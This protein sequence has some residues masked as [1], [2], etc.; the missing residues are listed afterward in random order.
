MKLQGNTP[1]IWVDDWPLKY[2]F[3]RNYM[4]D[5]EAE[6]YDQKMEVLWLLVKK[7]LIAK[8]AMKEGI[9]VPEETVVQELNELKESE[10]VQ[11]V[12]EKQELQVEDIKFFLTVD[13]LYHLF[14][15]NIKKLVQEDLKKNPETVREIYEK[16]KDLVMKNVYHL[17]EI[18]ITDKPSL[19]TEKIY[20]LAELKELGASLNHLG[21]FPE[22]QLNNIYPQ[23]E[24]PL[25]GKKEGSLIL[26]DR[27]DKKE[28]YYY[29]RKFDPEYKK[30][31]E[32]AKEDFE[33]FIFNYMMEEALEELYQDLMDQY[34]IKYNEESLEEVLS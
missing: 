28:I 7:M 34:E 16:N 26:I 20:T 13:H 15:E 27:M 1:L 17:D 33:D 31:F 3:F 8:Q 24:Y 4:K 30:S 5:L 11:K 23:A 32:E 25:I 9:T 18:Q 22:K 2:F 29:I 12:L 21:I 14:L 6:T 19:D 10:G